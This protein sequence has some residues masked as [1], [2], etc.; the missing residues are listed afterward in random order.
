M[1]VY[2]IREDFPILKEKMNG[3]PLIYLDNAATSLKPNSVLDAQTLYNTKKS[4]NVHRGVYKLSNDATELYENARSVVAK[5]INA[6]YKEVVFTKSATESLNMVA[7]G[8][9]HTM[10]REGD[11]IITSELEHHSSFLPW[12]SI[13]NIN[14][15]KLVKIPLT[16]DGRITVENVKKV[17]TEKTKVI[18]LG[19][20]S[21]VMGYVAPIKE[22]CNLA[23][24]HGILTSID[25]AQAAPHLK[26]DVKDLGCDFLSFTGHKML[27]PTGVGVLYGKFELL[28]KMYPQNFGGEMIDLVEFEESTYKDAP[29]KHEAGTPVIA[30][31]ISLGAAIEYLEKIGLYNIHNHE[32]SLR[33]LAISELKNIEGIKI[34]NEHAETGII[35]F[36][37]EGVHPH[38]MATVYD[39]EGVCVRAGHH[40][41]QLLMKFLKQPATLRASI[42]LYNTEE[43]IRTFINA[44]KKG[45]EVF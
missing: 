12:Q 25:A 20:V 6:D 41:A 13:A 37:L 11:E 14:G 34:F 43:D 9:G 23:S 4:A 26:I 38:D 22:I 42:Y 36:N 19:Y 8:F 15:G 17:I 30:G 35:S 28:Q 16:E 24:E 10:I 18:A 32:M 44:T 31:A 45:R 39:S 33:R 1:D 2:K 5:F 3:M 21:N 29:F 27:A 7:N 40:C